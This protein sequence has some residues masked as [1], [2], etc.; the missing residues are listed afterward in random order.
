MK[1]L[2]R[3]AARLAAFLL[4]RD[5]DDR[6]RAELDHHLE[7]QTAENRRAGLPPDEARRQAILKLGSIESIAE[8]YRDERTLPRLEQLKADVRYASRQLR[9]SPAF[10]ATA[11]LTL[12][13]GIGV[14]TTMFTVVHG[15]LLRELPYP[16][17]E[18]LMRLFQAHSGSDVTI[19]EFDVVR[20][21]SQT[22]SSVAAYRG[23]G[24]RR[25][26]AP[27][28]HHWVS[29][30]HVSAA[31]LQTLGVQ[32]QLGRAFSDEETR[33]GAA[34]TV[35]LSDHVWRTVFGADR[36][37]VGRPVAVNDTSALV[38][39]VL[40]AGFWFPQRADLLLPLQPSG[41]LSD[42]GTNTQLI[43]RVRPGVRIDDAHAELT[44][45]TPRLRDA[46]RDSLAS[47]YRGLAA[48]S[49]RE[50]LVGD[51]RLNL[52][53]LFGATGVLLLIACGNLALLLL[54]RFASR[55]RE[56]AV[57]TALGS[58][59]RR[60]LSQFLTEN[61]LITLVGAAAGVW[62]AHALV[63]VFMALLPFD[64]PASAAITVNGPALAFTTGTALV[65]AVFVTF[66]PFATSRLNIPASLL[67]DGRSAGAGSIAP[68]TRS[69]FVIAEVAL[70]TTLLVAA[71]LLAQTLHRTTQQPLGFEPD[72]VLTFETPLSPERRRSAPDRSA[73]T[74]ALLERLQHTP[75]VR[76]AAAVSLLPLGGQSNLPT[77]R[78]GHPDLSIGGMEVRAV[79]PD[80]FAVMGIPVRQGR[81]ISEADLV[82]GAPV[83]LVS[84]TVASRWWPEGSGIGDRLTIGRFRGKQLMTD[85][86]REVIGTVGDT[87]TV[88]LQAPP[89][90]TVYV[91]MGAGFESS[92]IAWVLKGDGRHDLSAQVRA[93]VATVDA[94]QR[95]VRLRTMDDILSSASATPRFNASLFSMFAGVALALTVVGLYGVLS[96][97]VAQRRHEI[98]TRLAL[99]ASRGHV[100]RAFVQQGVS[101]TAIG[102][103]LGLTGAFYVARWLTSLLFD[104]PPRDPATFAGVALVV[105]ATGAAASYLPARRAAGTDPLIA[106][107]GD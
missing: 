88:R 19:A 96:F 85:V 43:A 78:D 18:R 8:S 56:I 53:L 68:R 15:V 37:I 26:G 87:K 76:A 20:E 105:L 41:S 55:A 94:R 40:P 98:G 82:S 42:T 93:A 75:G 102:L 6:L 2:R 30:V 101:L 39:G 44:T 36:A 25:V 89:R 38:V 52:L 51:V 65:T 90:P 95:I 35:I 83:V 28:Q 79:T 80:Y 24:G 100:L 50:S 49:Y 69:L 23:A 66:V 97:V 91:P 99:G 7:M 22:F 67:A 70:A 31:F 1:A 54:T 3:F 64:L 45:L 27:E 57:R 77:Q 81:T 29:A 32:P 72:A 84:E 17:A 104:V 60:L 34:Q 11:V 12:A 62:A 86:S 103:G 5:L 73:F 33:A 16:E 46:A 74:R 48:V 47:N 9:R 71:G 59:R 61:L 107:R 4:R 21:Q 58:S 10:A 106:M 92:S 13:L 14:N 63:R